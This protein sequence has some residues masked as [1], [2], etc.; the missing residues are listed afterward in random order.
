MERTTDIRKRSTSSDQ[1]VARGTSTRERNTGA[2]VTST[3]GDNQVSLHGCK[4]CSRLVSQRLHSSHVMQSRLTVANETVHRL[5]SSFETERQNL[6]QFCNV[7]L[8]KTAS[9][10]RATETEHKQIIH[11]RDAEI[12]QLR[13]ALNLTKQFPIFGSVKQE[14]GP[15]H[16]ETALHHVISLTPFLPK[17]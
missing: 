5:Q 3:T 17:H 4:R 10:Q 1:A 15:I 9:L 11:L 14:W 13:D 6:I 7:E 2:T 16:T 8:Q 12:E